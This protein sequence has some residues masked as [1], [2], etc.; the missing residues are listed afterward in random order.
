MGQST[1]FV[2]LLLFIELL[3]ALKSSSP[4]NYVVRT[5]M[6][7][8]WLCAFNPTEQRWTTTQFNPFRSRSLFSDSNLSLQIGCMNNKKLFKYWQIF[9]DLVVVLLLLFLLS[10]VS[11]FSL[12][13]Q[14]N[15]KLFGVCSSVSV[16]FFFF[17]LT[18]Y[19]SPHHI[20]IGL[21]TFNHFS[22][23]HKYFWFGYFVFRRALSS[24]T[25]S[26]WMA[27]KNGQQP[28]VCLS[29]LS[30]LSIGHIKLRLIGK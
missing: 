30:S 3:S 1:I 19:P 18:H 15:R 20:F 12:L 2:S 7:C 26:K 11:V 28:G 13:L 27:Y 29:I 17:F 4:L 10:C 21:A 6:K 25:A 8:E 16:Q 14:S 5:R 22:S 9:N 23:E 24:F